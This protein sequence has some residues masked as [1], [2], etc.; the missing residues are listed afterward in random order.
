GATVRLAVV[1]RDELLAGDG[2]LVNRA[3]AEI[4]QRFRIGRPARVPDVPGR[5][6]AVGLQ[7]GVALAQTF[8]SG[9]Q[10][11]VALPA[12]TAEAEHFAVPARGQPID[13]ADVG[14][15]DRRERRGYLAE[16]RQAVRILDPLAAR[17]GGAEHHGS[18]RGT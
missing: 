10:G 4:P 9:L 14:A 8:G 5:V 12:A 11:D 16:P 2:H 15:A 1:C 13:D 3:V 17:R 7:R 6:T 18:D